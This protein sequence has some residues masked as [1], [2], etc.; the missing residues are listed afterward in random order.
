VEPGAGSLGGLLIG[1][2]GALI[3]DYAFN[4]QRERLGRAEFEQVNAEAKVTKA[5][6]SRALQR[7]LLGAVNAWLD[8]TQTIVAEQKLGKR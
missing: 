2:G 4:W 3:F 7:D 6:L 1:A 5:E 8:D